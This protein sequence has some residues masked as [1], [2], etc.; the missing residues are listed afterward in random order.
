MFTRILAVL[1]EYERLSTTELD[2][3]VKEYTPAHQKVVQE[4][5]EGLLVE[6]LLS[7]T[8]GRTTYWS[9]AMEPEGYLC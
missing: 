9:L 2:A 4:V 3:K 6:G 8:E 1:W 7:K 5:R